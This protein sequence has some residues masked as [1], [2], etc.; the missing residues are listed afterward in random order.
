M[1]MIQLR[2]LTFFSEASVRHSSGST[3]WPAFSSAP[4]YSDDDD[5]DDGGDD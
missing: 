2:T 4:S 1:M 3:A 5:D